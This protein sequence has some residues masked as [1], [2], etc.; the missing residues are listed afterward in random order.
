MD[1]RLS[2][3]FQ[4]L[5]FPLAVWVVVIHSGWSEVLINGVI[6]GQGELPVY[7][8]LSHFLCICTGGFV[9]PTF[10][11]ISGFLFFRDGAFSREIYAK[12]LKNRF[13]SLFIPYIIW[14]IGVLAFQFLYQSVL[15]SKGYVF[16]SV[17]PVIEY[18][19]T[20]F[21][22]S[23]WDVRS[24]DPVCFQLWYVRDIIILSIISP[25]IWF[26]LTRFKKLGGLFLLIILFILYLTYWPSFPPKAS[27][28]LYF[29]LGGY[30]SI[31]HI[32]LLD[33]FSSVLT[34]CLLCY[35]IILLV[36]YYAGNVDLLM[37]S[38]PIGVLFLINLVYKL[39]SSGVS[40]SNTMK[41]LAGI[42]FF[43]YCL[44]E[45][46]LTILRKISYILLQPTTD[47]SFILIWLVNVFIVVAIAI[48]LSLFLKW[49]MAWLWR[50]LN[51]R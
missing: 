7:R 38:W 33:G 19:V 10:L 50:L 31:Y 39:S 28:V 49:R 22:R 8:A 36:V 4:L 25:L 17:R 27:S 15:A 24:G 45:P 5:R 11:F 46:L 34:R 44:H 48:G 26:L 18:D 35:P 20:D 13:R 29:V 42:S 37:M 32:K 43:L 30:F 1:E 14:N 41:Y 2:R 40:L 23:F 12:K 47:F 9:V 51:G 3:T 6:Y 21:L 16:G